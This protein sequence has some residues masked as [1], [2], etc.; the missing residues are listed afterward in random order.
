MKTGEMKNCPAF[1]P[2]TKNRLALMLVTK[3]R[4]AFKLRTKN[5]RGLKPLFLTLALCLAATSAAAQYLEVKRVAADASAHEEWATQVA[6]TP[7]GAQVVSAG[8]DG[9]VRFLDAATGKVARELKLSGGAGALCLAVSA[10]GRLV[11]A[12]DSRGTLSVWD[13]ATGRLEREIKADARAVNA[14]AFSEDGKALASGGDE[15]VARVWSLDAVPSPQSSAAPQSTQ[16]SAATTPSQSSASTT[17]SQSSA[18][19]SSRSS[20]APPSPQSNSATPVV[21][22]SA[23]GAVVSL[24]FVPGGQLLAV[25]ALD[26][27]GASKSGVGV[28]RWRARERVRFFEGSPGVRALAVSADGRLLAA[29]GFSPRTLLSIK[30]A[31]GGAFEASVRA[32]GESDEA[33]EVGVWDLATGKTVRVFDAELGADSISFSGDGR[34]LAAAGEHGVMLFDTELLLERGRIDTRTRVDSVAFERAGPRLALAREREPAATPGDGGLDKLFDPFFVAA[35]AAAKDATPASVL[36]P[37]GAKSVTGGSAVEVWG[38]R[39]RRTPEAERLWE[40]IR[41]STTREH[42]ADAR[43]AVEKIAA[44]FPDFAEARRV[45]TVLSQGAGVKGERLAALAE[46]AVKADANCAACY[47]TLGDV[48]FASEEFAGAVEAYRRALALDPESGFVAGRLA[49]ALNRLALTRINPKDRAMMKE[50]YALLAEARRLRPAEEQ[51]ITNLS[52][53]FY[54]DGDFDTDIKLLKLAERLRPDHARVYYNLGHSYR[55]K[56]QTEEAL[57]A[58]RRYVELGEPGEEERVERAKQLIEEL[59]KKH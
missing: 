15:G 19:P 4:S 7:D 31:E 6:F 28:W 53:L 55:H 42:E 58:Y 1:K 39:E 17:P 5:R 2:G 22:L 16:S 46:D 45:L 23:V 30:P 32:L 9:R 54:F 35:V 8:L 59:S 20:A 3:G 48:L 25:G 40:A 38:V 13:A 44:D 50:A 49:S 21:E 41:L 52:S 24:A 43:K 47:R 51:Y 34:L 14:A 57:R 26:H 27:R 11:A 29:A 33:A 12:G 56:G 36:A 37:G 18:A 10:D